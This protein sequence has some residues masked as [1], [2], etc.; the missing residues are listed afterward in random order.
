MAVS[1]PKSRDKFLKQMETLLAAKPGMHPSA[2]R[3][4]QLLKE[5]GLLHDQKQQDY[6]RETDPFANVR[7]A[8]E[9]GIPGWVYA[10]LRIGEKCH[11]L[12]A[13]RQNG[14]LANES[15][16]DSFR[17]LAVYAL[18]A[19]VLFEEAQNGR[20]NPKSSKA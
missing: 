18:I 13:M 16:I 8:E 9:W 10:M 5:I 6:G 7:S 2:A 12:Q 17:D 20:S 11:R 3:F 19:E 14:K 1:E 15:A 4:H